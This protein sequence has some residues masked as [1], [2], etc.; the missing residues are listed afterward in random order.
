VVRGRKMPKWMR[1][2]AYGAGN[3]WETGAASHNP[4]KE[5]EAEERKA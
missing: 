3:M 5:S 4:K 2:A 1:N